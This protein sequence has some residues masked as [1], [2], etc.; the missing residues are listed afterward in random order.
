[1][2]TI[3][4]TNSG[5]S[6]LFDINI[7]IVD[8][9]PVIN[10]QPADL[11]MT[12][13]TVSNDLPLEPTITGAGEITSWTI[14][15]SMPA[16]LSF[17]TATGTLSGTPTE[18]LARTMF[19][20]VGTNTG[21]SATTYLNITINDESPMIEYETYVLTMINNT[22][23]SDLPL[24]AIVTGSGEILSWTIEPTLPAGIVFDTSNG[25][26]SGIPTELLGRTMFVING[27]NSG[28][29]VTAFINITVLSN[30]PVIDYIPNDI[31]LLSNSS[32]LDLTPVSNGGVVTEW[33]I[34]PELSAGLFFN[35]TTGQLSGT[36]TEMVSRT[37]YTVTATNDDGTMSVNLNITVEDTVY[38]VPSGP[39]Y[40]L[41]GS[42]VTPISPSSTIAGST[43]EIHPELPEGMSLNET[44][45]TI[46]GTPSEV[47]G[48]MNFTV[49]SNSSLFNDSFVI[50]LEVLEDTDGDQEPDVLPE[51]YIGDLVEDLDDDGDG[52]SDSTESAC[53]T[54]SQDVN[55]VPSDLDGD[56][57]CD[58]LDDDIDGDG[59]P[60]D[61]ENN[62]GAHINDVDELTGTSN[63]DSDADGICDGPATPNAS[64]CVPGP[65]AFP[66]DAAASVDTDGDGMP[67]DL[68][69][70]ST[71]GLIEDDDDDDDGWSDN[72]ESLCGTTDIDN[73]SSPLDTDSDGTCDS[74]DTV[75][76]LPFDMSYPT[77]N[78]DLT[79]GEEMTP[80]LPN[81]TGLGEVAS[82]ELVG[83]L[84]D[85]LVFGW[86]PARDAQLDGSIRGTPISEFNSTTYTIWGNNS[87][88]SRSYE[89]TISV[90]EQ[91]E[92]DDDQDSSDGND[93][94][95]KLYYGLCCLPLLLLLLLLLLLNRKRSELDDA[96]PE[97]TTS[98]PKFAE[99]EGT[100]ENPFI[101][102]PA[103]S[104]KCGDTILSKELITITNITPGLKV[105]FLDFQD[106]KNGSK[107]TMQD[108]SG[109]DEGVRM[110]EADEEGS[111]KFRIIFDDSLN[112]T[113]AG[114]EFQGVLKVGQNSVYLL[115]DVKVKPDPDYAKEQKKLEASL[116]KKDKELYEKAKV[117]AEATGRSV[118]S[119]FEDLKDDGVVNLSNE[120]DGESAKAAEDKAA[121]EA[122]AAEEKAA[123]DAEEKAAKEAK[124]AEEKAAKAAKDAE[125]KAKKAAT[126]PA[127]KEVKKQEELQRVKSRAKTIDFKTLGTATESTLKS[128]VV[129]GASTL[130][131]ANAADFEES[132]TAA[133]RDESGSSV[134][135][136]TGKKGN[137]LTG[138]TGVTRVFSTKTTVMVKD[139]L[140]VIKG[141]GPFI[142]EK[143]NALGITTYRQIANMT[144]KLEDEVNEAIEFFPG[145]V[146]RDQWVAQAKILLGEDV[147][148][149]QKALKEAE[150]LERIAQKAETIDFATLGVATF[151]EKDDL[152]IIKG[153]GPF[154][155][156][157]L[158][159]LGIYTF[160]QVGNMTPKIEEEVNKAIEFFPG[161]VKRD[162][163]AKQARE[164]HANKK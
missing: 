113:L 134:I 144:A 97:N 131:V 82:W 156:E 1:M 12:N 106:E 140:Q 85:G 65:D 87:E 70:E 56:S 54:N 41:N 29:T 35:S 18:L 141:I 14:S 5:G 80:L 114:G 9:V 126:K 15:P 53:M 115:W 78:L 108:H 94:E 50:E 148:L 79:I 28:G 22:V 139:D 83:E 33:S 90:T 135:S 6:A 124:A 121:K 4:G 52:F 3:N 119:T 129:K 145:R 149:D 7:T 43:F 77:N 117:V 125:E 23:S 120:G 138:V 111:M 30:D 61:E 31:S 13:N 154:I 45:G 32:I 137:A 110:I 104:V 130:E 151:D 86:S 66:N 102:K 142:E 59:I 99:G 136:W 109:S 93:S 38:E 158:Y 24:E 39:I 62:S 143:L 34:S 51:G 105:K 25:T 84:P 42:S 116:K 128:E 155:A 2:F 16:G 58:T 88:V 122:K 101:L 123:K 27:T 112:P 163:W 95:S 100:D 10:Y 19:T 20:I 48:L 71:T 147:K 92:V 64:I 17:D 81:I 69:G 98:K 46:S 76:D 37:Q 91:A 67:D 132:G 57:T 75:L 96:E 60:N 73:N 159:A 72:E 127:T 36:P 26:I 103:N 8:E 161:R 49:Y 153:I 150:D 160:E 118:E 11:S 152:Q 164:L 21:G 55:S 162:Q 63:P 74:L 47:I 157:K 40:L 133:L 68:N 89:V 44:D 146:K 107:F